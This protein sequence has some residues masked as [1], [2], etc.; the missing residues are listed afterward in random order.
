MCL[1]WFGCYENSVLKTSENSKETYQTFALKTFFLQILRNTFSGN[2]SFYYLLPFIIC[3]RSNFIYSLPKYLFL[4][5]T[6]NKIT[7]QTN[8][9]S[10]EQIEQL[11][12]ILTTRY[13]AVNLVPK[14]FRLLDID[15]SQQI[16]NS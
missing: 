15:C 14:V 5:E 16:S 6:K 9:L 8:A 13:G 3:A 2:V 4:T 12:N 10:N 7:Y 1:L 11:F